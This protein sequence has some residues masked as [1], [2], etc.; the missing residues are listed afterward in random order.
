MFVQVIEGKAKDADA[1]RERMQVWDR[2]I[3][4]GATGF[5]GSTGGVTEDGT[6]IAMARFESEDA[7]RKNSDRPEQSEWWAE[8]AKHLDGDATFYDCTDVDTWLDGGSDEAGFVQVIQAYA[9][10]KEKLRELGRQ[11]DNE[12]MRKA[13]PDVIG[14]VVAWGP[15]DGYSQFVY[16]KSEAEAREN[17]QRAAQEQEQ[18][19]GD[20]P[21]AELVRDQRYLDIK[22]PWLT[23]P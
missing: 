9:N 11:M 4:P 8:T 18:Q 19:E 12:D 15:D 14:G 6:F 13:R 3:K 20:D 21:W 7:A 23:S 5:L 16:F 2:E 10:D 1:L 22:D 17:E